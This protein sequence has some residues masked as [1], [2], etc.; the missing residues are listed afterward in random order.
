MGRPPIGKRAMTAAERQQRRRARLRDAPPV[1]KSVTKQ[2]TAE[3]ERLRS[4]IAE[5]EARI[6]ELEAKRRATG[7]RKAK[8][9]K[10][11][12]PPRRRAVTGR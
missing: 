4:R 10:G 9:A 5:L 11:G 6:A 8:H 1:T 3:I 7:A 2:E 12:S